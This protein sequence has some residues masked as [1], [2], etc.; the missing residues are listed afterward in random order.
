MMKSILRQ[1][2]F[3]VLPLR[4]GR[5]ARG[6][7]KRVRQEFD[8]QQEFRATLEQRQR[9]IDDYL[10]RHEVRKLQIG[11]G[12]NELT[13]WLNTDLE[14]VGPNTIYLDATDRFPFHDQVFDYIYSEHM[15]EH[16]PYPGGLSMLRECFRVLRP[17]GRLRIATPDMQKIAGLSALTLNEDQK[18]YIRWSV[19]HLGLYADEK[20]EFQKRRPEW[21]LDPEHMRAFYPNRAEHAACFVVNNFFRSYGHQFLYDART[22]RAAPES[23]GF[24]DVRRQEVGQSA[25]EALRGVES[26]GE[27]IGEASNHFETMIMEATRP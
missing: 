26:H 25:D 9:M 1:S 6:L 2:S 10:R 14:P 7:W 19:D 15:I 12:G 4:F 24:C 5:Q 22:M 16:I 13:G 17:G 21:D 8:Q 3:L 20:S 27:L 23:A 18:A 11:T